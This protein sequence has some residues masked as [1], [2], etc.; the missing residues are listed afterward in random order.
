MGTVADEG[1]GAAPGS[2]VT[3]DKTHHGDITSDTDRK[4]AHARQDTLSSTPAQLLLSANIKPITGQQLRDE[5]EPRLKLSTR[6]MK[7]SDVS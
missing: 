6:V 7:K 3:P 4:S 5:E 2:G 1:G